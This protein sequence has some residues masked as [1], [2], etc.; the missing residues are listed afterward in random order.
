MRTVSI[1]ELRQN[2][3][4]AFDAVERGETVIVTRYRKEIGRI[5]PPKRR[6]PPTGREVMEAMRRSPLSDNSWAED[7]ARDRAAFDDEWRDPWERP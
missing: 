7:L 1:A 2:P 4:P 3:N 5:V 6:R